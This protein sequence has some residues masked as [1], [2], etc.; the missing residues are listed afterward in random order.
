MKVGKAKCPNA[1]HPTEL[2]GW[3]ENAVDDEPLCS[4]AGSSAQRTCG[5]ESASA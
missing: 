2:H 1:S 5:V 3:K 4:N